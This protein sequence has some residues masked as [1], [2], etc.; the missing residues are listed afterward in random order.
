MERVRDTKKRIIDSAIECF[1]KYGYDGTSVNMI[2]KSSGI[3]KGSF[4]YYFP[5]KQSLFLEILNFWMQ[6]VDRVMEETSSSSDDAS[7]KL[8]RL[9][10]VLLD[11]IISGEREISLTFEFW[12]R[13]LH[14]RETL[15]KIISMFERYR[16]YFSNLLSEGIRKG[17]FVNVDSKVASYTIVAFA[18]GL[19]IQKLFAFEEEDWETLTRKG[20]ELIVRGLK[21]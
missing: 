11:I 19:L 13:A 1:S 18:L 7:S 15:E 6:D 10:I 16:N 8:F 12:N 14:D 17:E 2:C 4:F 20:L 5:T 9:A 21:G 3:S